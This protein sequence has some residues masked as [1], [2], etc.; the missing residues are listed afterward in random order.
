MRV[1][2]AC[3]VIVSF[4]I[5]GHAQHNVCAGSLGKRTHSMMQRHA[6]QDVITD[7]EKYVHAQSDV[8]A[9]L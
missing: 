9:D 3:A 5:L 8:S 1:A 4:R 7:S 2:S 6:L